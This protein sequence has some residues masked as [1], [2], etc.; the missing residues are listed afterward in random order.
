M[1]FCQGIADDV[2]NMKYENRVVALRP[3][4]A[5]DVLTASYIDYG[6]QKYEECRKELQDD[7]RFDPGEVS[8]RV[9]EQIEGFEFIRRKHLKE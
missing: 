6:F 1:V 5:G 4:A 9:T 7:Y 8:A 3:V 2:E